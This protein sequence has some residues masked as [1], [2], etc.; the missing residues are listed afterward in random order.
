MAPK[1]EVIIAGEP[2]NKSISVPFQDEEPIFF[3]MERISN[4]LHEKCEEIERRDLYVGGIRVEDLQQ[5]MATYRIFGNA[6]TYRAE[7]RI[8]ASKGYSIYDQRLIFEGERLDCGK[9]VA[10]YNLQDGST[11]YLM[12][13]LGGGGGGPADGLMFADVSDTKSVR[14]RQLSKSGPPGRTVKPGANIECR[15]SAQGTKRYGNV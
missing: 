15:C 5:S 13:R 8:E 11:I 9:T 10:D 2:G 6:V 3:L 7:K 4:C 1:L 12:F 14:R